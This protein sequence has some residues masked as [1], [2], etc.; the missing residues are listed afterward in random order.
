MGLATAR[1]C[2]FGSHSVLSSKEGDPHSAFALSPE[3][4]MSLE[5]G[6]ESLGTAGV[7]DTTPNPR[8]SHPTAS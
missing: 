4:P 2:G 3:D 7:R 5:G 8:L 6:E 1:E